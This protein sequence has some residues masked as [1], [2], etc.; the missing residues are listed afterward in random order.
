M[1]PLP[2]YVHIPKTGGTTYCTALIRSF[3]GRRRFSVMGLRDKNEQKIERLFK[4]DEKQLNRIEIVFG[5]R[6]QC[7]DQAFKYRAT[8]F[9]TTIR[10]P[11]E[12]IK[13]QYR[14]NLKFLA[15]S[16][17]PKISLEQFI[18]SFDKPLSHY[19]FDHSTVSEMIKIGY[20]PSDIAAAAKKRIEEKYAIVGLT[21]K[22]NQSICLY[23]ELLQ[24]DIYKINALNVSPAER[25]LEHDHQAEH[26]RE[27]FNQKFSEDLILYQ[28]ISERFEAQWSNW[29]DAESR[30]E[31]LLERKNRWNQNERRLEKWIPGYAQIRKAD[32]EIRRYRY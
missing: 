8:K 27:Y 3:H 9:Y 4:L 23:N 14:Q 13:S 32:F 25:V 20:S 21:E 29:P 17:A 6:T 5:H 24:L 1:K 22:M 18:E 26:L 12:R 10:S 15:N 7:A 30:L 19:F 2:I 28:E 11:F 16:G 31:E